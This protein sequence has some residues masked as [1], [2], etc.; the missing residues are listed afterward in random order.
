MNGTVSQ[1]KVFC[2]KYNL[3]LGYAFV[4]MPREPGTYELECKAWAPIKDV[5]TEAYSYFLGGSVIAKDMQGIAMAYKQDENREVLNRFTL[6]SRP[7]GTVKFRINVAHQNLEFKKDELVKICRKKYA[8]GVTKFKEE[9]ELLG[10]HMMQTDYDQVPMNRYA[11]TW[12]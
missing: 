2:P 7:T 1:T 10:P 4:E 11:G 9:R 6:Q 8:Q 12:S 3:N 5:W